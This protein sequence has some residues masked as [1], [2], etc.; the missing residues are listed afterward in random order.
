MPSIKWNDVNESDALPKGTYLAVV[1]GWNRKVSSKGNLM[2]ET[3]YK[4]VEPAQYTG[5]TL[6]DRFVI[7]T[8]GFGEPDNYG[9][10]NDDQIDTTSVGTRI[11][12]RALK[13]SHIALG[14]DELG[15]TLDQWV[16][17]ELITYVE[18]ELYEGEARP[19]I[20]GYFAIGD[21][22]PEIEEEITSETPAQVVRLSQ[23]RAVG[24]RQ[25]AQV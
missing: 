13:A 11:M 12:K 16:D 4:V 2:V 24:S 19:K 5:T 20:K 6:F 8:P 25:A 21:R 9:F 22:Q 14:E 17:Q 1:K 10:C 7:G 18:N 15:V 23:R 3:R